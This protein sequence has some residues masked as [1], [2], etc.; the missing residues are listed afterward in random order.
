VDRIGY[1]M[2]AENP[3]AFV[4]RDVHVELDETATAANPVRDPIAVFKLSE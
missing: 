2:L 3:S 1:A 4:S